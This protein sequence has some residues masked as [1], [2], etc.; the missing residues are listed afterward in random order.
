MQYRP[1]IDGLRAVAVLPVVLF[2][3]GS[4]T[5]SGGFVG[6]DIFFVI[7][8]Y[9]I[10]GIIAEEIR[11]GR[12][13]ILNFYERRIRRLFP[14]LFT[15]IACSAVVASFV[16]MPADFRDFGE[17][18]AAATLFVA[19]IL[20]WQ[21]AGYFDTPAAVKPLLHAWSLSVEEQFYLVF[22]LFMIVVHRWP[23]WH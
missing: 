2:H 18:A 12:F 16:F 6:V 7:S 14:A 13:T 10:G 23:A 22:P 5:F 20:F 11:Q 17:S 8:G 19:N 21:E 1:D 3:A 15:V 9:L 4:Q